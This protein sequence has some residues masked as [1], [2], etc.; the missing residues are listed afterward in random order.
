MTSTDNF[1]TKPSILHD[2]TRI[3][4]T[5]PDLVPPAP[6]PASCSHGVPMTR[7]CGTCPHGA[8]C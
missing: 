2:T 7:D 8:R 3:G 4:A 5:R 6:R 1:A